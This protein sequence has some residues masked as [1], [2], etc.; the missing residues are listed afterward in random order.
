MKLFDCLKS[1]DDKSWWSDTSDTDVD[2]NNDSE[3][4]GTGFKID[5][6]SLSIASGSAI[7]AVSVSV[8][9]TDIAEHQH[10]NGFLH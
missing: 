8:S 4:D 9:R 6:I 5:G 2:S 3:L 7:C 1:N 10:G